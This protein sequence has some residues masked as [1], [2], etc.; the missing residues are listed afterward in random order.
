MAT[1]KQALNLENLQEL[2]LEDP[3]MLDQLSETFGGIE[4]LQKF[5]ELLAV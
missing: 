4:N 3:S 5:L 2:N 1:L